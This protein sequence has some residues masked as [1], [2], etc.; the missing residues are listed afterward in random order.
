[1]VAIDGS[2]TWWPAE[3]TPA[4]LPAFSPWQSQPA[5]YID[6][7]NRGAT[8]FGYDIRAGEP[9]VIVTPN[10][11]TVDKQVRASVH[12]DWSRAPRGTTRVPI[13]VT[14]PNATTAT[15]QAGTQNDPPP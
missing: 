1:G 5:Q 11:G 14:G 4:V 6:V 10:R 15:V 9:W 8:P 7:F 12:I 2:D 3:Q 13:T